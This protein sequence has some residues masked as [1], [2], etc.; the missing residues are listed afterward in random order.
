M[1]E[2][3]RESGMYVG[4]YQVFLAIGKFKYLFDEVGA[5]KEIALVGHQE[6]RLDIII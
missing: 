1:P 5:G 6:D 3:H 2:F 4:R